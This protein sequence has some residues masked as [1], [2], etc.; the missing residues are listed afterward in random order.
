M[1]R[2]CRRHGLRAI[3]MNQWNSSGAF[4][5]PHLRQI[6]DEQAVRISVDNLEKAE[7]ALN[8]AGVKIISKIHETKTMQ[9][10]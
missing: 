8:A 9:V 1:T 5:M 7:A 6:T 10:S 4:L 3:G 2:R